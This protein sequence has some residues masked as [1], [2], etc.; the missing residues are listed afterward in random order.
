MHIW[1]RGHGILF[2]GFLAEDFYRGWDFCGSGEILAKGT[3]GGGILAGEFWQG[4][5]W[6]GNLAGQ[7]TFGRGGILADLWFFSCRSLAVD[8]ANNVL[9]DEMMQVL[10]LSKSH[11]K[12]RERLRRGKRTLG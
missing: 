2:R 6:R 5:F 9:L 8:L 1:M 7:G 10:L 4:N 3:F 12:S 11:R